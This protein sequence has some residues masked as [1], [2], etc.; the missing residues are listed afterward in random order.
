[1]AEPENVASIRV[2][3]ASGFT[4]EGLLRQRLRLRD[5]QIDVLMYSRIADD[6]TTTDHRPTPGRPT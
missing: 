4:R 3:E 5:R 2:A 1:V 6:L